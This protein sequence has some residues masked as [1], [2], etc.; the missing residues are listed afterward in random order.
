MLNIDVASSRHR[1]TISGTDLPKGIM[2]SIVFHSAF[3]ATG[4]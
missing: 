4:I 2:L 3:Q 1:M